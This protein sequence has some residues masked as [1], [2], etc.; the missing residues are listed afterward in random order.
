VAAAIGVGGGLLPQ[1][2]RLRAGLSRVGYPYRRARGLALMLIVVAAMPSSLYLAFGG[3]LLGFAR[4]PLLFEPVAVTQAIDWLGDQ[5]DWQDTTFS[6]ERTGAIIPARIGHRVYLG[7]M[8]E[9]V[10]YEAKTITVEKFF[11]GALSD[12]EKHALLIA[13]RCRFVFYGPT[14]KMLGDFHS[15]EFLRPVFT[16]EAVTIYEF[17]P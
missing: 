10:D 8:F 15:P 1:L 5:S 9:T 12:E 7:H 11:S 2:R 17:A 4:A 14:E 3:A 16:N 6:A 13:C